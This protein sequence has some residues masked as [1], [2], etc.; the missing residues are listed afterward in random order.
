[1]VGLVGVIVGVLVVDGAVS[2]G[3]V[4]GMVVGFGWSDFEYLVVVFGVIFLLSLGIKF[5]IFV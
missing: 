1:L 3:E 5:G 2:V 4:V